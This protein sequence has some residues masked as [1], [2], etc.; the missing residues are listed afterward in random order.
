MDELSLLYIDKVEQDYDLNIMVIQ[1]FKN[2]LKL[3]NEGSMY[4]S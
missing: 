1:E 3:V 4:R 2:E